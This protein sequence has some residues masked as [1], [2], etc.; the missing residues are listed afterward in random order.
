MGWAEDQRS[1]WGQR[2][3]IVRGMESW[4]V[5]RFR[6][7][8]QNPRPQRA[9]VKT[10]WGH[11]CRAEHH[12]RSPARPPGF[13]FPLCPFL[14]EGSCKGYLFSLSLNFF[15]SEWCRWN[16]IIVERTLHIL[17]HS[18]NFYYDPLLLYPQVP[19]FKIAISNILHW[20]YISLF[21]FSLENLLTSPCDIFYLF[22]FLFLTFHIRM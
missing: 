18:D 11:V 8:H 6:E 15:I 13:K 9:V 14:A 20:E 7:T 16:D 22:I 1:Q 2:Q 21:Y 10:E 17:K 12:P 4:K 3:G 19:L 5:R